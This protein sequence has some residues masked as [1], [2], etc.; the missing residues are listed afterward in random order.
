MKITS[1]A[2]SLIIK[3]NND[4]IFIPIFN[5]TV[6]KMDNI[7]VA[8]WN[9]QNVF[10]V[11]PS[12]ISTDLDFTPEKGWTSEVLDLKLENLAS[13]IDSMF[14]N[15]G[16]DILGLCEIENKALVK[17]LLNKMTHKGYAIA[18]DNSEDLRGIDCSLIY[19]KSVIKLDPDEKPRGHLV[20]LRFRTRDIFEVPLRI[21]ENDSALKIFVNHWP[22][23]Y[24]GAAESDAFRI[25]VAAHLGRLVDGHLKIERK[26]LTNLSNTKK[27][28]D[29][30]ESKWSQNILIMGDFND[31]PFNR[32][33]LDILNAGNNIDKLEQ[34][35]SFKKGSNL[36]SSYDKY[37]R[38]TASLY[39]YAWKLLGQSGVGTIFYSSSSDARTKQVFDQILGSRGLHFGK[40]GL[41]TLENSFNV[42]APK[43]MWSNS[44]LSQKI[45]DDHP[46]MVRPS[47]FTYP[48]PGQK[49]PDKLKGYSDHFPVT[50]KLKV[51]N[52]T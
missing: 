15:Q 11:T 31:D 50:I 20:H 33:L 41:K 22:S 52:S 19:R 44:R 47:R 34:S 6:R 4:D 46:F 18:H 51:T 35:L 13:I 1:F 42:F 9:L 8:F 14:E 38:H 10:D 39:N 25:S 29:E 17:Q 36:I 32:S 37:L 48:K 40:Q 12:E 24:R 28:R 30:L 43:Q 49:K 16:P 5:N 2:Y 26:R 23:R 3:D 45:G 21:K 27:S 7:N